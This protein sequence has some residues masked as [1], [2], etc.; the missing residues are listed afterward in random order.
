MAPPAK[1]NRPKIITG[2][3]DAPIDLTTT[4]IKEEKIIPPPRE[5]KSFLPIAP[6][7]DGDWERETLE[8]VL[9]P[10]S[11]LPSGPQQSGSPP[12]AMDPAA[13][14][15]PGADE[16]GSR[17][18]T[19]DHGNATAPAD[20]L[21]GER[22]NAANHPSAGRNPV[23]YEPFWPTAGLPNDFSENEAEFTDD[24][25]CSVDET[26]VDE[27]LVVDETLQ[28][29][30][31]SEHDEAPGNDEI[32]GI[33]EA[34]GNDEIPENDESI[35]NAD[36]GFHLYQLYH[37][38]ADGPDEDSSNEKEE[39][40]PV[41]V[42][43]PN[44]DEL[45]KLDELPIL[46]ELPILAQVQS[47]VESANGGIQGNQTAIDNNQ[48]VQTP[49]GFVCNLHQHQK[50][51]LKWL[52]DQEE[53]P[54]MRGGMLA[55]D[56]GLGKTLQMLALIA[57]RHGRAVQGTRS[58]PTLI[59]CPLPILNQWKQEIQNKIH[60]GPHTLTFVDAR[61]PLNRGMTFEQFKAYDIVLCTYEVIRNE[62]KKHQSHASD[63]HKKP[64]KSRPSAF[65]TDRFQRV[66]LDESQKIKDEDSKTTKAV[67]DLEAKYR[68]LVTG[69]PMQN[70]VTDMYSSIAFLRIAPYDA[71]SK[72]RER[73]KTLIELDKTRDSV[74]PRKESQ[75]FE[76][77]LRRFM[78]RRTKKPVIAGL[79]PPVHDMAIVQLGES[80]KNFYQQIEKNVQTNFSRLQTKA[81]GNGLIAL[82][83]LNRLRWAC[84][85]PFLVTE[86]VKLEAGA[87]VRSQ[88]VP[89]V[90]QGN[91]LNLKRLIEDAKSPANRVRL[92][93]AL[94]LVWQDSPKINAA[95]SLIQQIKATGAKVLLF[96]Q[97]QRFLDLIQYK[98]EKLG[99]AFTRFDGT[100]SPSQRDAAIKR[101][102]EDEDCGV[103]LMTTD[104]GNVGLN[105]TMASHVILMEPHWNPYVELQAGSR[106]HRIGQTKPVF[107]H[108]VRVQADAMETATVEDRMLKLQEFKRLQIDAIMGDADIK[109]K[110]RAAIEADRQNVGNDM[111]FLMGISSSP[112]QSPE[113]P[114]RQSDITHRVSP[115]NRVD[116]RPRTIAPRAGTIESGNNAQLTGQETP[117]RTD[118]SSRTETISGSNTTGRKEG[119]RPSA[120][121]KPTPRVNEIVVPTPTGRKTFMAKRF[122]GPKALPPGSSHLAMK[123]RTPSSTVTDSAKKDVAS[124]TQQSQALRRT[125]STPSKTATEAHSLRRTGSLPSH[126]A[127]ASP[128]KDVAGKTQQAQPPRETTSTPSKIANGLA[129]KGVEPLPRTAP[130]AVLLANQIIV[131]TS[132]GRNT[133][134]FKNSG[135]PETLPPG[136]SHLAMK[137]STSSKTANEFSK[138]N[139]ASE[140]H[141]SRPLGRT[142]STP[143]KTATNSTKKNLASET[144]KSQPS[145]R[146]NSTSFKTANES[147]KKDVRSNTHQSQPPRGTTS[148]PSKM[149]HVTQPSHRTSSMPTDLANGPAK[150]GVERLPTTTPKT[151]PKATPQVK[152][153]VVPTSTGPNTSMKKRFMT[154]KTLPPGY[155]HLAMKNR[156]PSK[157]ATDSDSPKKDVASKT[158]ES[159]PL[160]RT[161][162]TSSKAVTRSA[163]NVAS[164]TQQSRTTNDV[165][166]EMQQSRRT[167]S[168]SSKTTS[169]SRS[170]KQDVASKTQQT[171]PRRRINNTQSN[172]ANDSS[173]KDV[174]SNTQQAQKRPIGSL[175]EG[176]KNAR[177]GHA[178][179]KTKLSDGKT[180]TGN[181]KS[182]GEAPGKKDAP[183]DKKR[184]DKDDRSKRR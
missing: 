126:I 168:T 148:T 35:P 42:E 76:N 135:G 93:R 134:M 178:A 10:A 146:T 152:K 87:R 17:P 90:E 123:N 111:L 164:E 127:N 133:S 166:S 33:D 48:V 169:D 25:E 89:F 83:L 92:F 114:S 37:Q 6:I 109:E 147:A 160:G 50:Q 3:R 145:H 44:P 7:P 136:S 55:D 69:T 49:P 47:S 61:D 165:A 84:C 177:D 24:D 40:D 52:I 107:V 132:T 139:I 129:K 5:G 59:I 163:K 39:E 138:K 77:M 161:N 91:R 72:F 63:K 29:E 141:E 34:P 175:E 32:A 71:W 74:P 176:D 154:R 95:I 26:L 38:H 9:A 60:Q 57:L 116:R 20:S 86:T 157:T 155:S 100:M 19:P 85:H 122:G 51:G 31:D 27:T 106:V 80:Y 8:A 162:S 79:L 18:A 184:R 41:H 2:T 108:H 73:W 66:I 65:F 150:K 173:K 113:Q 4:P 167:N 125:N 140:T 179:K 53:N 28:I 159:R 120:T 181:K 94:D 104:A 58:A 143:S 149:A 12:P 23:P 101:L 119:P 78:L 21:G 124:E 158:Q 130:E 172:V 15:A 82:G 182:R 171:Q 117:T 103:M 1:A 64:E 97:W 151:T 96:S 45:P 75:A 110:I 13:A 99:M 46:S 81:K 16:H 115:G 142:N 98:M 43:L 102:G 137:N 118:S 68:W 11:A 70:R 174:A 88:L 22:P 121:L 67:W 156:T 112:S 153:T 30:E 144:Q 131:P 14:T 183:G 170:P 54:A 128:K 36:E 180:T 56:M 105:L 62:H